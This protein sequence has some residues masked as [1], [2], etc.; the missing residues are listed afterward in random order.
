MV[1]PTRNW[2]SEEVFG[3]AEAA[4][5]RTWKCKLRQLCWCGNSIFWEYREL[6]LHTKRR[7]TFH[8]E[9]TKDI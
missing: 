4:S 8:I 1:P 2:L 7:M 9:L 3:V 5:L 6:S